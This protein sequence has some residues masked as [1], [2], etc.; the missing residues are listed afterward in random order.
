MV[1]KLLGYSTALGRAVR[2]MSLRLEMAEK[3]LKSGKT[4]ALINPH[5]GW[6]VGAFFPA[7]S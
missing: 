7:L 4:G 6:M 1:R 5:R 3:L 2:Y